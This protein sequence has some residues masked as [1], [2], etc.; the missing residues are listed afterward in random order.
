MKPRQW[1]KKLEDPDDVGQSEY[2]ALHE[3]MDGVTD[4]LMDGEEDM[5][6]VCGCLT[7]VIEPAKALR[8]SAR[9]AS[10][11][12]TKKKQPLPVGCEVPQT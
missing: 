2:R 10:C 7:E 5:D 12:K 6:V 1:F 9:S 11:Q 8:K 4:G 3:L